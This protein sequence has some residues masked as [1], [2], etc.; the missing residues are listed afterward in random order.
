YSADP[1]SNPD[2]EIIP[3][4]YEIGPEIEKLAKGAGSSFGTG[5]MTTKIAAAKICRKAKIHTIITNGNKPENIF[6]ILEGKEIG[7]HFLSTTNVSV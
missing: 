2:A 3:A 7:T 6:D 1:K 4:V 5:G